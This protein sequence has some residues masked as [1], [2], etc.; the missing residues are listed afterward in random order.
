MK[1]KKKIE[2]FLKNIKEKLGNE[3]DKVNLS[4]F[5]QILLAGSSG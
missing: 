1:L 4:F 5:G 3:T 2:E